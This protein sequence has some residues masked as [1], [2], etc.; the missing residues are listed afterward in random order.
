MR[1]AESA[2]YLGLPLCRSGENE[3]GAAD[4]PADEQ[5]QEERL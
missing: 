2:F 4:R 1:G 3:F 5:D